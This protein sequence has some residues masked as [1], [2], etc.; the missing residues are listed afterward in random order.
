MRIKRILRNNLHR[1]REQHDREKHARNSQISA[2]NVIRNLTEISVA[3]LWWIASKT[4]VSGSAGAPLFGMVAEAL[5]IGPH[6]LTFDA[7]GFAWQRGTCVRPRRI[8]SLRGAA[9]ARR[10][11]RTIPR[12]RK[13]AS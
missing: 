13:G 7:Q 10:V 12:R 4:S 6:A 9:A 5:A 3:A 8:W 2:L 1:A 11:S